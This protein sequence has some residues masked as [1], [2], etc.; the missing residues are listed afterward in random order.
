[1]GSIEFDSEINV[2]YIRLNKGKVERSEPLDDN[3]IMD[4]DKKGKA[5]GIEIL[6]PEKD[7]WVKE[8]VS[9]AMITDHREGRK[10]LLAL[11]GCINK[12][13]AEKEP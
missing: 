5:I 11:Y 9:L 6:L 7:S 8:L 10:G 1:M 13:R 3:V 12:D 4:V 2:M